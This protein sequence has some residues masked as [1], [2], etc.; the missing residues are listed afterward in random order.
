ML[1]AAKAAE[2]GVQ[3]KRLFTTEM[4]KPAWM[5]PVGREVARACLAHAH[6]DTEALR[7]GGQAVFNHRFGPAAPLDAIGIG[8]FND[9]MEETAVDAK[10][11][12]GSAMDR[13][14]VLPVPAGGRQ[15]PMG[16]GCHA[17]PQPNSYFDQAIE[18]FG[19]VSNS[20][21]ALK[22]MPTF[23]PTAV[24]YAQVG[25]PVCFFWARVCLFHLT[26]CDVGVQ[27]VDSWEKLAKANVVCCKLAKL[28][29]FQN[30]EVPKGCTGGTEAPR[31]T[32][33]RLCSAL[34]G[35]RHQVHI[36]FS[37]DPVF[38]QFRF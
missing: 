35:S 28:G 5:G 15:P 17:C 12:V 30:P 14:G 8:Y 1:Q 20:V 33:P 9:F 36:D 31:P 22:R 6:G 27:R 10:A 37:E 29:R 34:V 23:K 21:T 2:R 19:R 4:V 13:P 25:G 32:H 38:P 3:T 16:L 26:G 11:E 7:V 24:F 18:A